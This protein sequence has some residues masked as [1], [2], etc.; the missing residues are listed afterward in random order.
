MPAIRLLRRTVISRSGPRTTTATSP[1]PSIAPNNTTEAP[2]KP[3]VIAIRW[4]VRS[5]TRASARAGA[6][7]NNTRAINWKCQLEVR[8]A[9]LL[10]RAQ[11]RSDVGYIIASIG[12]CLLPSDGVRI[13]GAHSQ[14]EGKLCG[15]RKHQQSEQEAKLIAAQPRSETAADPGAYHTADQQH[16]GKHGVDRAVGI[17]L[18]QGHI[19]RNEDDLQQRGPRYYGG[20]HAEHVNHRR[21]HDEAAAD[22][23]N[24]AEHADHKTQSDRQERADVKLRPAE[25]RLQ[26]QPVHPIV[27]MQLA[28]PHSWPM[29]SQ[30]GVNA[31]DHHQ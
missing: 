9:S 26:R 10:G 3:V 7:Q 16:E 18:K 17:G 5:A 1:G 23:E 12:S 21:H 19:C 6:A 20:W 24:C 4:S 30:L 29:Q 15:D 31:L 2:V 22:A 13:R 14:V 11:V 27:L 25:T 8:S 28:S